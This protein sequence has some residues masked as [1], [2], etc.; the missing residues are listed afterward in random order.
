[1]RRVDEKMLVLW[2]LDRKWGVKSLLLDEKKHRKK[3]VKVLLLH[4]ENIAF[5]L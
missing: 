4:R 3:N 1:M 2:H 5:I